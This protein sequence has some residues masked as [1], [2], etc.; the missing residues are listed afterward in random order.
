MRR[1]GCC[2]LAIGLLIASAPGLSAQQLAPG[3]ALPGN[4]GGIGPGGTRVAPGPSGG[5]LIEQEGPGGVPLATGS[6]IENRPMR[7]THHTHHSR[8][9][10]RIPRLQ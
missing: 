6:D 10:N 3:P 5:P 4:T 1:R 9:A 8:R 7:R 2:A